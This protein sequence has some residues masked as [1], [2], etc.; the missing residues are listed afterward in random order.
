MKNLL[1][2]SRIRKWFAS[3]LGNPRSVHSLNIQPPLF[4]LNRVDIEIK[5]INN[6]ILL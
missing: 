1:P 4:S 3:K 5:L 2:I 6:V